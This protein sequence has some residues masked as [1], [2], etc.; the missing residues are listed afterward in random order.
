VCP[1]AV[2]V[3]EAGGT[4]TDLDGTP[5]IHGN[6]ALASNGRVHDAL[7]AVV[8]GDRSSVSG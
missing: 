4:F 3:R 8:R 1:A 6:G 5:T 2:L 7:L